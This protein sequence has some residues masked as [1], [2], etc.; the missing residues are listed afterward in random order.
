MRETCWAASKKKPAGSEIG[1]AGAVAGGPG[2]EPGLEESESTVLPLNYPPISREPCS[3][4]VGDGGA[5]PAAHRAAPGVGGE[6][7]GML[8]EVNRLFCC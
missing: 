6:I 7:G 1:R 4:G 5:E 3:S 8:R 2:F